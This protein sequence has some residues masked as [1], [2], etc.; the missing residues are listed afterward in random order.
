MRR[1]RQKAAGGARTLQIA[2]HDQAEARRGRHGRAGAGE[3]A[4]AVAEAHA[5]KVLEEKADVLHAVG[6]RHLHHGRHGAGRSRLLQP[7]FRFCYALCCAA[8]SAPCRAAVSPLLAGRRVRCVFERLPDWAHRVE[9]VLVFGGGGC[10]CAR[11]RRR[12]TLTRARTPL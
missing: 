5:A 6:V 1:R 7:G 9:H 2:E 12:P 11:V 8:L 3:G 10:F 4:A